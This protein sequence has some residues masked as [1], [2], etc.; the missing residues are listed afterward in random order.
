MLCFSGLLFFTTFMAVAS[1][2]SYIESLHRKRKGRRGRGRGREEEEVE[3]EGKEDGERGSDDDGGDGGDDGGDGGGCRGCVASALGAI[4]LRCLVDWGGLVAPWSEDGMHHLRQVFGSAHPAWWL[5]P[6][7]SPP[8]GA[9][10]SLP[11]TKSE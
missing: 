4:G 5:V 1:G 9:R 8:P 7:A 6:R 3:E 10:G 2:E 11:A